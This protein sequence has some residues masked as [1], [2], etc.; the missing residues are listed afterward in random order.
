MIATSISRVVVVTRPTDYEQ[1]LAQ[2]ATRSQAAFFLKSRG[3]CLRHIEVQHEKLK[4]IVRVAKAMVPASC[5]LVHIDRS[6]LD[7]FL[8]EPS[9]SIVVIGQD[10]LVANIAKY[11]DGQPVLG[12]NPDPDLFEGI[13]VPLHI[14]DLRCSL[15]AAVDRKAHVQKRTLVQAT[16]DDGQTLVALNELFIGH[17][18]H[19]SARYRIFA[20]QREE[21]HSS[22]GIIVSTG[23]GC[24]GWACSISDGRAKKIKLPKPDELQLVFFVREAFPSVTTGNTIAQGAITRKG[25][26]VIRSEMNEGGVIFGDGMES[27]YITFNWG[28][29]ACIRVSEKRLSLVVV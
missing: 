1:L 29:S 14:G 2:H 4:H 17:C 22:S 7:R 13:L 27:D 3:E 20:N 11:L 19:Q 23:T 16:L 26:L 28:K 25:K 18:S 8:F 9:D 10:G 5:R 6:D 12:V 24:T 21:K 15:A